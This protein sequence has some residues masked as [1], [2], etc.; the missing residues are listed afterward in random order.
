MTAVAKTRKGR[1]VRTGLCLAVILATGQAA[2]EDRN[3]IAIGMQASRGDYGR[4]IDTTIVS[5]PVSVQ[6]RRGRWQ[7]E[8][9]LPWLRVSGDRTV[10]PTYGPVPLLGP[11]PGGGARTERTTTTGIGDLELAAKYSVDTGAAVGIDLG[12]AAKLA[13][14][15][16]A[17]GLGTG[18]SDYA[19]GVDIHRAVGDTL[20]FA[21]AEHA[22]LGGSGRVTADTQQRVTVGLSQRAGPGHLGVAYAQRS[23]LADHVD[24]RRDATVFYDAATGNGRKLQVHASRGLSDSSP[25]WGLG[26]SVG[27]TF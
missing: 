9:S 22:W 27:T 21:G 14:A 20:L 17:R 18:A 1:C 3:S 12:V 7:R 23:A 19:I 5:V 15:D 2:A 24:G 8:A 10:L 4:E 26:V 11:L 13:T 25:D 6:L 16:E